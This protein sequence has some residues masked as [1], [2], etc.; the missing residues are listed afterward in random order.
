V[1]TDIHLSPSEFAALRYIGANPGKSIADIAEGMHRGAATIRDVCNRLALHGML[2]MPADGGAL[3]IPVLTAIGNERST[4]PDVPRRGFTQVASA[5]GSRLPTEHETRIL[6]AL[7]AR[8]APMSHAEIGKATGLQN[9]ARFVENLAREGYATHS[10]PRKGRAPLVA[11]TEKGQRLASG[12]LTFSAP[13]VAGPTSAA[14]TAPEPA[15]RA[16]MEALVPAALRQRRGIVHPP[17]PQPA[18]K[19]KNVTP[20]AWRGATVPNWSSGGTSW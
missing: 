2:T 11:L 18:M 8:G 7:L 9:I 10:D 14:R 17:I 3:R 20:S 5:N 1:S 12:D 6:Q 16:D 13:R 19:P 4:Q 15:V